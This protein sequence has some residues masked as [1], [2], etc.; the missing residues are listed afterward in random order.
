MSALGSGSA[1]ATATQIAEGYV[2]L[3]PATLRKTQ[4]AELTTLRVELER[5][6]RDA[7]AAVADQGDTAALQTRNR[8][9]ARIRSALMVIQHKLASRH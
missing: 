2:S 6:Q 4:P 1:S 3:S 9:M 8:K 5:L 7:R